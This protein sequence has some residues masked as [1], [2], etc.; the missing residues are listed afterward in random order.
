LVMRALSNPIAFPIVTAG[1]RSINALAGRFGNKLTVQA[2][3]LNRETD[4]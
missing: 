3:R 2:V 4:S 1:I